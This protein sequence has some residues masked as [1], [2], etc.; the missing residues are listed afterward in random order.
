MINIKL[1]RDMIV[2]VGKFVG[3]DLVFK[4]KFWGVV[5]LVGNLNKGLLFIGFVFEVWDFWKES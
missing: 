4:F 2:V 5:N 3:V 1:V